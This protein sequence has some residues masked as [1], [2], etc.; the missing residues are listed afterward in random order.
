MK[1]FV[2]LLLFV[3]GMFIISGFIMECEA[4]ETVSL[5]FHSG[6]GEERW[7]LNA[8]IEE[9]NKTRPARSRLML[10]NCRKAAITIRYKPRP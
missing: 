6:K 4:E 3:V 5:W 1:R 2:L 9:F 7:A 10:S 8:Q